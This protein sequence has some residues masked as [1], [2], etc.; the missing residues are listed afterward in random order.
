MS[1]HGK[2]SSLQ[3]NNDSNQ[4]KVLLHSSQSFSVNGLDTGSNFEMIPR[5]AD[6]PALISYRTQRLQP[7][8]RGMPLLLTMRPSL[9]AR[10]L[11]SQTATCWLVN[12]PKWREASLPVAVPVPGTALGCFCACAR[13]GI[14]FG[15]VRRP[16]A[17]CATRPRVTQP[18]NYQLAPPD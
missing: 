15:D 11:V 8:E 2:R 17:T 7:Q 16:M 13:D 14:S 12:P 5:K 6:A 10:P 3:I 1:L 4:A 9:M 18:A